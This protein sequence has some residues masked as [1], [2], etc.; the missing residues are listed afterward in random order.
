MNNVIRIL[1]IGALNAMKAQAFHDALMNSGRAYLKPVISDDDGLQF[2]LITFAPDGNNKLGTL[3]AL[4]DG[5]QVENLIPI[6]V[7]D[8]TANFVKVTLGDIDGA[9]LLAAL[10]LNKIKKLFIDPEA[11]FAP[12]IMNAALVALAEKFVDTA[13]VL[14]MR[15]KPL[16]DNTVIG[17]DTDV[18]VGMFAMNIDGNL[19]RI[20]IPT[21]AKQYLMAEFYVDGN[22]NVTIYADY[23]MQ[24]GTKV[25]EIRTLVD[26]KVYTHSYNGIPTGLIVLDE[27]IAVSLIEYRETGLTFAFTRAIID[28]VLAVK[29]V[30]PTKFNQ[31]RG[32]SALNGGGFFVINDDVGYVTKDYKKF[33]VVS[34][35]A[36]GLPQNFIGLIGNVHGTNPTAF[37]GGKKGWVRIELAEI[38]ETTGFMLDNVPAMLQA[39]A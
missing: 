15:F 39:V 12:Q 9:K 13:K 21:G 11:N 28:D 37:F 2:E 24:D 17:D 5:M 26:S 20:E 34:T 14:N 10:D 4:P 29:V 32:I 18:M 7:P 16:L 38:D 35:G 1:T 25:A 8:A 36:D 6:R 30:A 19:E 22:G 33:D 31:I 3:E 23:L 27:G